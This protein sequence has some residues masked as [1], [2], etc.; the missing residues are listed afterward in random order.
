MILGAGTFYLLIP[1]ILRFGLFTIS[2]ISWMFCVRKFLDL[3]FS[4]TDVSISSIASSIP[5]SLPSLGF[6][7]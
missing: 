2:Q 3:T 5:E 7:W 1:I 4:L 6:C